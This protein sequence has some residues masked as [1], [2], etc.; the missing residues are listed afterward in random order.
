MVFHYIVLINY[1]TFKLL[2]NNIIIRH[3]SFG[4]ELALGV[5]YLI[6]HTTLNM[7]DCYQ[8]TEINYTI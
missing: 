8:N 5:E 7:F 3:F 6:I 4:L 2:T 1:F